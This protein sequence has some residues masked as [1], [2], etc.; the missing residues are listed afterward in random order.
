MFKFNN[1][2]FVN[3]FDEVLKNTRELDSS[4]PCGTFAVE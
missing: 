2:N 1:A 4:F 3:A